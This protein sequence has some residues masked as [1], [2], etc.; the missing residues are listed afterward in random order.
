[1]LGEF[2][3]HAPAIDRLTEVTSFEPVQ[4]HWLGCFRVAHTA[5]APVKLPL[6]Y[7]CLIQ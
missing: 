5:H 4:P 7:V 3:S 6:A 1:L 2:P